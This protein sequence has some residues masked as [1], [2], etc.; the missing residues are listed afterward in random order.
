[1]SVIAIQFAWA[2]IMVAGM[3]WLPETPRHLCAKGRHEQAKASLSRVTAL[4][5]EELEREYQVLK[6]GLEAEAAGSSTS[7]LELFGR[8]PQRMWLRTLTGILI[9][10]CQQLTG[11]NFI[12]Y[13]GTTFFKASGISNPFVI[14]IITNVV[15]VV[16]T[17]PGI[18]VIDKI[19]R[20]SLLFWA[21]IAMSICEF[22]VA[23][24][25]MTVSCHSLC[26]FSGGEC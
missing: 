4:S 6:E 15:N 14:S 26:K 25:G 17:I 2:V 21:A 7:Y 3:I 12:F 8:G 22:I 11:I 24:V 1:M 18:V 20:R 5:G 9:Q 16:C 13:F 10:A 23:A 19:G